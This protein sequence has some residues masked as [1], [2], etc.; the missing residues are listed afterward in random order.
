M[1]T[2]TGDLK[3]PPAGATPTWA[4]AFIF[5]LALVPRLLLIH[6]SPEILLDTYGYEEIAYSIAHGCGIGQIKGIYNPVHDFSVRPLGEAPVPLSCNHFTPT[7]IRPPLYPAFLSIFYRMSLPDQAARAAQGFLDSLVA[8]LLFFFATRYFN[9]WVGWFSGI[10]FALHPFILVWPRYIL[11]ET[12]FLDLFT[13]AIVVLAMGWVRGRW[14]VL[15]SAGLLLGLS[16]LCRTTS[17]LIPLFLPLMF[18]MPGQRKAWPTAL[19][20]IV[21]VV[22]GL[23]LALA[24]WVIRNNRI[25]GQRFLVSGIQASNLWV[26]TVDSDPHHENTGAS[27]WI[28]Y[29][30]VQKGDRYGI[31]DVPPGQPHPLTV[32]FG[33]SANADPKNVLAAEKILLREALNNIR[34]NPFLF[35]WHRLRA[36]P[37]FL[38]ESFYYFPGTLAEYRAQHAWFTVAAKI[39]YNLLFHGAVFVLALIGCIGMRQSIPK[40]LMALILFYMVT[41]HLPMFHEVRYS[42]PMY[43]FLGILAGCGLQKLFSRT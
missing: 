5:L 31:T 43:P 32:I 15:F 33:S 26:A 42:L 36:F 41:V 1:P 16:T 29:D 28:I 9:P 37:G 25:F 23:G 19:K 22:L 27:F 38:F 2:A 10:F 4:L 12:L 34:R 30:R 13:V 14:W 20:N 40:F 6:F 3:D 11:T 17:L 35:V 18:L 39:L 21:L 8:V 7:Y 24:P